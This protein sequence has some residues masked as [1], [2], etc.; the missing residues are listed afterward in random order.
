M[1]HV[2][3]SPQNTSPP[4]VSSLL[5][6]PHF[7]KSPF[8]KPFS[9]GSCRNLDSCRCLSISMPA[10]IFPFYLSFMG[11]DMEAW[12]QR[13]KLVLTKGS[14]DCQ[15]H[16]GPWRHNALPCIR[17]FHLFTYSFIHSKI[18]TEHLLCARHCDRCWRCSRKQDRLGPY[19]H[20]A[21]N[22]VGRNKK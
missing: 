18:F 10:A 20:E 2:F 16:L 7:V 8:I 5:F 4:L 22:L 13:F 21:Y 11:H 15:S 9:S 1:L 14:L 12:Y 6:C 17:C 3:I 19:S